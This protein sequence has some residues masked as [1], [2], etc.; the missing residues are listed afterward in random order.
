MNCEICNTIETKRGMIYEDNNFIAYLSDKPIINGHIIL[1]TKDHTTILEL[2]DDEIIKKL[3]IVANK[4]SMIMF[5]SLSIQGTNL[6]VEN[7]ISAGQYHPHFIVNIIPRKTGD[8]L[9]FSWTPKKLDEEEISTIELKYKEFLSNKPV[10]IPPPKEETN[11]NKDYLL[12]QLD[13][14]P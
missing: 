2:V 12:K 4:I 13:R 11:I 6:I 8:G 3:F 10:N 1:T 9:N 7:G 14:V 5:N